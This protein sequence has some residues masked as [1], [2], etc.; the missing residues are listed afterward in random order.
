MEH[1]TMDTPV[2]YHCRLAHS[3][4]V[5]LGLLK[6]GEMAFEVKSWGVKKVFIIEDN[7]NIDYIAND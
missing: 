7:I 5:D 6:E 4:A 2:E 3:R 1:G